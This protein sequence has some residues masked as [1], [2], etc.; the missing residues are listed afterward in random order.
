MSDWRRVRAWGPDGWALILLIGIAVAD[1]VLPWRGVRRVVAALLGAALVGNF[2]WD[3]ARHIR[4]AAGLRSVLRTRL[5]ELALT[6]A[7]LAL[8]ASKIHVW[9]T[10]YAQPAARPA[11][12]PVYHEYAIMFIVAA[13]L[14]LVV[15][16]F[17]V[18]RILHRLEFRPAQ[19]VALGFALM[20]LTGTLL[21]SLPPAVAR[22]ESVSMLNAL[23]TA[24]SAVTVTGL[25]VYDLSHHTLLGQAI[26]LLLIQLGGLGTMAASASLVILAGRR[27]RLRSAAAM[28]ESMD[29]MTLGQVRAHV[30]TIIGVT[31]LAEG[32]G[33]LLLYGLWRGDPAVASPGFAA[34]FHAVSAFCNAG[35]S[36][37]SAN[38]APFRDH[39]PT[40]LVIAALIVVGGLGFPV[41][42]GLGQAVGRQLRGERGILLSLHTRLALRMTVTLLLVGT[43]ALLL[44][45]RNGVLAE[46]SWGG[47]LLAAG[48]QSVTA[49]TAGFNTVE[50]GRL[51][52]ATLWVL[53]GLM[54][55]GGCPGST[56]GGVK[57]TT[58]ATILA[59]LRAT[60]HGRDRVEVLG[61]TIP[62]EQVAK[63]L[64]VTGVSLGMVAVAVLG[65]LISQAEAPLAVLFEAVSAFGT[66]GLSTGL[67][68]RLTPGGKLMIMA[69]MF[70]GRIGP[71][72]LGF[73]IA[74]KERAARV[75]YPTEKIMIG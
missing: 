17:S 32:A 41:L 65:L 64:A 15:G 51:G 1:Y 71:L 11:L 34:L 56:A 48:F 2:L 40:N 47:R 50:V 43:G 30:R 23:F 26:L 49:R 13:T 19:T 4:M 27:L 69:L 6:L 5:L 35:F 58:I 66:V 57:T 36:T 53:M 22:L 52:P 10:Y 18:R 9:A 25:T 20:I 37:F 29:L 74:V 59:T 54:F 38:L 14:R 16:A 61:R 67:T 39:A 3:S 33:A 12:E 44:L 70:V 75:M 42:H 46:A 68:P 60:L 45:E 8:L 62:A 24:T 31:L 55:V 73:A 21:L 7:A 28:Q 72:T 63:A